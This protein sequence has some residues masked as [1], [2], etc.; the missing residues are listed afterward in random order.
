[1]VR[2]LGKDVSYE[3]ISKENTNYVYA[4]SNLKKG[5]KVLV[6]APDTWNCSFNGRIGTVTSISL[7]TICNQNRLIITGCPGYITVL[8]EDGE[9]GGNR[10][11]GYGDPSFPCFALFPFKK[12]ILVY[13][14]PNF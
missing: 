11:W 2:I 12:E 9:Y 4:I 1:V 8:G 13:V 7:C 6:K 14:N 5:D 10:C 3:E